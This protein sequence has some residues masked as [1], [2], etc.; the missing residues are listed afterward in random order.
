VKQG[1]FLL[2]PCGRPLWSDVRIM[3]GWWE[4]YYGLRKHPK[5]PANRALWFP[6][7]KAIHSFG[8][9]VA[10]D[11][12]GLNADLQI[13]EVRRNLRP[14]QLLRMAAATSIIECE[15][16]VAL[17]LEHWLGRQL[18]FAEQESSYVSN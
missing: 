6:N 10:I 18:R 15:A 17:P 9:P 2:A 3:E 1:R 12:I 14:Q 7:C 11:V 13:I 4:R 8:M 5:L 16:G